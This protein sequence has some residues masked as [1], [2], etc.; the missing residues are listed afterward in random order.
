MAK[1]F[2]DS[3]KWKDDWY[4]TLPNDYK[5]VWQWLLDNCSHS[6]LCK[7]SVGLLNIMCKVNFTEQEIIEKMAG[8]VIVFKDYWFI[9][10]FIKFQ[11]STLFSNKPAIVSV[12]KDIFNFKLQPLIPE[13]FGND[14]IITEQ[15]FDNH[16]KIIKDKVKDK[17]KDKVIKEEEVVVIETGVSD[18]NWGLETTKFLQDQ[19][20][21]EQ[22][23]MAKNVKD[24]P[25][26]QSMKEFV[27]KLTLQEDFKNANGL[28]RHY[29]N[30]FTKY[31]LEGSVSISQQEE[32]KKQP[33][34]KLN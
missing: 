23:C 27:T 11:Y 25:L 20:W 9:P 7:R 21:R 14:Y 17:D 19:K 22:F 6:G 2:T 26:F 30:Y 10:K 1:R 29:T 31:G 18:F 16:C 32:T 3:E 8:R 4:I 34:I 33:K 12:V 24:K 5:I 13:S 28:K 15:S